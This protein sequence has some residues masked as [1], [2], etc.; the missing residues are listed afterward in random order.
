MKNL[1]CLK[2]LKLYV[3]KLFIEKAKESARLVA[4]EF[5]KV[6]RTK[7]I[8]VFLTAEDVY[9]AVMIDKENLF[10]AESIY[11][12]KVNF[13]IKASL[14]L[15]NSPLIPLFRHAK[16]DLSNWPDYVNYVKKYL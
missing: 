6:D 9:K 8:P 4:S 15:L 7:K 3:S 2:N 10:S 5:N 14:N 11:Y 13:P 16:Y 1:K 12:L